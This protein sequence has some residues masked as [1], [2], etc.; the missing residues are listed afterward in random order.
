[1]AN[2][3]DEGYKVMMVGDGPN[4]ILAFEQADSAVLT[5]EQKDGDFPDKLKEYADFVIED[6]SEVLQIDF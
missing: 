6:I 5:V 4:D 2:L 3:Q 1:M